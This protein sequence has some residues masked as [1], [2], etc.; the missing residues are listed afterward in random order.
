[1]LRGFLS[2]YKQKHLDYEK[3]CETINKV[4][5]RCESHRFNICTNLSG[6]HAHM[7]RVRI[8]PKEWMVHHHCAIKGYGIKVLRYMADGLK[9]EGHAIDKVHAYYQETNKFA[10]GVFHGIFELIGDLEFCWE[11]KYGYAFL[12][13]GL[14]CDLPSDTIFDLR[15]YQPLYKEIMYFHKFT[16]IGFSTSKYR[17]YKGGDFVGYKTERRGPHGLNFSHLTD[18]DIYELISP[19]DYR[20]L[21]DMGNNRPILWSPVSC[22][23]YTPD[24]VYTHWTIKHCP[25]VFKYFDF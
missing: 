10:Y 5:S 16:D 25:E 14:M 3:T 21:V 20:H 19:V 13:N 8:N 15:Y 22:V 6:I 18:C 2:P 23:N 24:K 11:T 12:N 9:R 17:V 1:M 4:Y 7:S